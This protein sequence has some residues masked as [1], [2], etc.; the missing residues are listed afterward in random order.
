MRVL[1]LSLV[2][3]LS[4]ALPVF[5]FDERSKALSLD[6][7]YKLFP[8]LQANFDSA[9]VADYLASPAWQGWNS[10]HGGNWTAQH[11]TL[12][13]K[14]R[15]VYGGA[16][17]W[18]GDLETTA[19]QFIAANGAL[20]PATNDRLRFVPAA[21]S[22]TRDGRI[23]YAAFDYIVNG[24]PVDSGRLVFAVNNGN[25][26]Y[27]NS[28]NIADTPVAT[29]PAITAD[30]AQIALLAWAGVTT[31]DIEVRQAP[32]LRLL[33]KNS[34]AGGL[35]T[36]VL[37]YEMVFETADHGT[38]AGH[39]D[40]ITGQVVAFGDTN[41]YVCPQNPVGRVSGGIRPAEATDAE[42]IRSFPL[43]RVNAN[44]GAIDS[45]VN[46]IFAWGAG[47][48]STALGGTFFST[49][50][51]DCV[52]SKS[53]PVGEWQAFTAGVTGFLELGA[54][55]G[56]E[57]T[58]SHSTISYGNGTSTPAERTAF[59]HT[60]VA[61]MMAMKWLSLGWLS[62]DN[63]PINVNINDTCNAFWNGTS[64]NF[65]KMGWSNPET[66]TL[67]CNNTGEIRD[68]MQH[69]WGHGL[70]SNDGLQPGLAAGFGDFATGEA[71]GDHV[72]LF[73]DHDSCIGQSFAN[74]RVTG[75][76]VT[77]PGDPS[78]P[79]RNCNGVR[80]VD[81]LRATR[82]KITTTNVHQK[83]ATA[84]ANAVLQLVPYYVGPLV[85]QG[86]CE[87]EIWGQT[88]WHLQQSLMTGRRY[89]T[90]TVG[91]DKRAPTYAGDPLPSG[92]NGSPNPA[93]DRHRAWSL[94]ERFFYASRPLVA[95]YAPSHLQAIGPSAYDGYMVVDDEGDGLANGTPHAAYINDAFA[96]HGIT[97]L[98]IVSDA[99]N[100]APL[101][102]PAVSASQ[103]LDPVTG[104]PAIVISWSPV[105]G[106]AGYNLLR[107]ERPND[108]FLPVA[109]AG[110]GATSVTDAGV[111]NGVQ[112]IYRVEAFNATGC[113]AGSSA[114]TVTA[115]AAQAAIRFRSANIDDAFGDG[116]AALDAGERV[117]LYVVLENFGLSALSNAQVTLTSRSAGVTVTQGGPYSYGTIAAG[118]A[119]G[120]SKVFKI[121][122][123]KNPALCGTVAN[124]VLTVTGTEGCVTTAFTLP[125]GNDGTSCVLYNGANA[126]PS[127]VA[128]TSDQAGACGDGD[129]YPDAGETVEVSVQ[130]EN[131]GTKTAQNVTVS[132]AVDKPYLTFAG[133]S[134]VNV[135][136][137]GPSFSETKTAL[138][139]L[140]VG[141]GPFNDPVTFTATVGTNQKSATTFANRD[142]SLTTLQYDFEGSAQ[143]WQATGAASNWTRTQALQTGNIS[144]VFYSQY[145]DAMCP[146]L[147]SP[148]VEF[149]STTSL[150][151]DL[152]YVSE[153]TDAPWDGIDVQVS[154]GGQWIKLYPVQ[155]YSTPVHSGSGCIP[156]DSPMF[157]GYSPL[158]TRYSAPIPPELAGK[159]G[160]VR[161][162]WT[163]DALVSAPL[164]G[165]AWVDNV[166]LENVAV[167][168]PD[169]TCP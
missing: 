38:W 12:S 81:E 152:A 87:G 157:S 32:Q 66:R 64:T 79:V 139:K 14:P 54:G 37:V 67:L 47:N 167:A 24:V 80:N 33:P 140:S 4:L 48:V 165:G 21:A 166:A 57:L 41:R 111:D 74:P 59:F 2:L 75:P 163:A 116:D 78:Y 137:L 76:F 52:K 115:S 26:I 153:N 112:Y 134:S 23:R 105:S 6:G 90:S 158:M 151:F 131:S 34:T 159:V 3:L 15:R 148:T 69:E 9:M 53:D 84:T 149:S 98:V 128:V 108:V 136:S 43:V 25:M 122:I 13:G 62:N 103:Q 86:H 104:M 102:T 28:T 46:G 164:V 161:F 73:V 117:S 130:V 91:A 106:A 61:R 89:G 60:N 110:A 169:L 107:T 30:A 123:D 65:F 51:V 88:G 77:D 17:P 31:S 71:V 72:A 155:G 18:P 16:I 138:F 56:D 147:I 118:G 150:S 133:P 11:D 126:R 97:E 132:L 114:G 143:G 135:G 29:T 68:V 10:A 160:Q 99:P 101:A 35:L 1:R 82:G 121:A 141:T 42:V 94:H 27:W 70:D 124:F 92:A 96:D 93:I 129:L 49:H 8:S 144:T 156:G 109:T 125:I 95:T 113:Y 100:C 44:E 5:A 55:G 162:R 36:Y 120:P 154:A 58:P 83:C 63:V 85:A 40:A 45:S 7:K 127:S 22:P 146:L 50:C 142:K 19:R 119:A 20:F 145:F 39:V 168:T